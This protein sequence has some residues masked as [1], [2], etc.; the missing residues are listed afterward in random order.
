[1]DVGPPE[2]T[3]PRE[4]FSQSPSAIP[5]LANLMALPFL[6]GGAG[7][8][9]AGERLSPSKHLIPTLFFGKKNKPC[10]ERGGDTE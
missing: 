8:A 1:M 10:L 3:F 6:G 9:E 5:S 2:F 4:F 7:V